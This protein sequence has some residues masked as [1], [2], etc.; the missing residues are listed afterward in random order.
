MFNYDIPWN[1]NRL[2]Q[3]MGRIHRYGRRRD[4]SIFNFV[5]TNTIEGRCSSGSWKSSRRSA[6]PSTMTRSS[7]WAQPRLPVIRGLDGDEVVLDR[8]AQVNRL[9]GEAGE[10]GAGSAHA[11]P[12]GVPLCTPR[13]S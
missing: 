9:F 5:A 12:F 7:T 10:C 3:R 13:R 1:P 2:E 6:T 11:A 4:C 8:L